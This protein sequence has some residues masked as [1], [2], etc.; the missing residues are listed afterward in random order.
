MREHS[1]GLR[2][3]SLPHEPS[4]RLPRARLEPLLD[5]LVKRSVVVDDLTHHLYPRA[6]EVL[7]RLELRVEHL[8]IVE[9]CDLERPDAPLAGCCWPRRLL[10]PPRADGVF[11]TGAAGAVFAAVRAPPFVP[12]L[13]G[14][15]AEE[16]EAPSVV[17][18]DGAAGGRDGGGFRLAGTALGGW[19]TATQTTTKS[20]RSRAA[21]TRSS[22]RSPTR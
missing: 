7:F 17:I 15:V 19:A 3:A 22:T 9:A 16:E 20:A 2:G 21:A 13:G 12:L 11:A 8:I 6:D 5:P 4:S 18:G 1:S 10:P 14:G